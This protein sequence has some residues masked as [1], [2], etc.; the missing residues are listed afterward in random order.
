MSHYF[1]QDTI[2]SLDNLKSVK[3]S[4]NY[5]K[6]Y[7]IVITYFNST[8]SYDYAFTFKSKAEAD[9]ELNKILKALEHY[10]ETKVRMACGK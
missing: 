5:L 4:Q 1:L 9:T 10:H 8:S 3:I 6:E 7:H 2:F